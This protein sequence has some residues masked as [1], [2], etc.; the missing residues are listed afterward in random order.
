[1][2]IKFVTCFGVGLCPGYPL[3]DSFYN[4]GR[5][6]EAEKV[7]RENARDRR[8]LGPGAPKFKPDNDSGTRL[9]ITDTAPFRFA[10]PRSVL[11]RPPRRR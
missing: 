3:L 5:Y 1:M 7:H 11:S 4:Q 9:P 10:D 6:A 2:S 8:V